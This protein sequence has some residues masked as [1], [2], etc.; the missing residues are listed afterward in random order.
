MSTTY[1]PAALRRLV[2][3]RAKSCCE[4][5]LLHVD[6]SYYAHHIDHVVAEKHGGQTDADNLALSCAECNL[7]KGTDLTSLTSSGR[8]RALFKPRRQRWSAHFRL[9]NGTIESITPTGEV[10]ARLL[11]FN[12]ETRVEVRK[13]L[14]QLKLYPR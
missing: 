5:C 11:D 13:T 7:R 1:I 6:D 2:E 14:I 4:Y 9:V 3:E 12:N 10:T 8:L